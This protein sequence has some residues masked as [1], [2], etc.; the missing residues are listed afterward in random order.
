MVHMSR[1]DGHTLG[2]LGPIKVNP[3]SEYQPFLGNVEENPRS[4]NQSFGP[5]VRVGGPQ[6][7][8]PCCRSGGNIE[9]N[10]EK[11]DFIGEK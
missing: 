6:G 7:L 3:R 5:T 4:E 2:T 10:R 8:I 11:H 1:V 9:R